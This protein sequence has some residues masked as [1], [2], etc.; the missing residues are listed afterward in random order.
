MTVVAFDDDFDGPDP[1]CT[2]EDCEDE[3]DFAVLVGQLQEVQ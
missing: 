2:C 1:N 3:R